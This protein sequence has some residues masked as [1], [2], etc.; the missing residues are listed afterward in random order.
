MLVSAGILAVCIL[1]AI[2]IHRAEIG[3]LAAKKGALTPDQEKEKKALEQPSK[4]A[5]ASAW[6]FKAA[7]FY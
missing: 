2:L 6:S 7:I 3:S 1:L 5:A 4:K